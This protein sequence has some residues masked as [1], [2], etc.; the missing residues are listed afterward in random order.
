MAATTEPATRVDEAREETLKQTI[1]VTGVSG[2]LGLRLLEP[3]RGFKVIGVDVN[4]PQSAAP[5]AHFEKVDLGEERSCVQ[6]LELMRAWRPEA[7]VHLAFVVDP[8]RAGV[9]DRGR[10]WHINVAG[11]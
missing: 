5:L 1:L 2:N 7:V 11:S 4:P 9:V 3:L 10:M 8:L 6:L